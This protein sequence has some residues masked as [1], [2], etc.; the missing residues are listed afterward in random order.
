MKRG[1]AGVRECDVSGCHKRW[2]CAMHGTLK[3]GSKQP[4]P[5]RPVYP[6]VSPGDLMLCRGCRHHLCRCPRI[7]PAECRQ[8][9]Y[10]ACSCA[11]KGVPRSLPKVVPVGFRQGDRV[12]CVNAE[13]LHADSVQLLRGRTLIV[14]SVSGDRLFFFGL[15]GAWLAARFALV[16]DAPAVASSSQPETY[17][18]A[19]DQVICCEST[20]TLCEGWKYTVERALRE[21]DGSESLWIL[22]RPY[23]AGRFNCAPEAKS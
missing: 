17:F 3:V 15:G 8:C 22:G 16:Q 13:G 10:D 1:V 4:P 23:N 6:G 11:P 19:G 20:G 14:D 12:A 18:K 5:I 2:P 9:G 21:D 7:N